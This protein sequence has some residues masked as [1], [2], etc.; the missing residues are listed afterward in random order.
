MRLY[1]GGNGQR[2]LVLT[3]NGGSMTANQGYSERVCGR[4]RGD[5][6]DNDARENDNNSRR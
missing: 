6:S 4:Y 3:G 2:D 1:E 5:F